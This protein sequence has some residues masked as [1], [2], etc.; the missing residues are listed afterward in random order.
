MPEPQEHPDSSVD[1]LWKEYAKAFR[2]FD[3]LSLAR[4]CSQTLSQLRG[5]HWRMSH[6]LVGAYRLASQVAHERGVWDQRLVNI[7]MGY[8]PAEC[9]G[10]PML[11]LFTREVGEFGLLCIHC[12]EP[13]VA[14][15]TLPAPLAKRIQQWATAY[16]KVHD[17]AHWDDK[18]RKQDD[19]DLKF[20]NAA[21]RV[22]QLL[23][24][25]V[26]QFLP[27]LTEQFPALVWED[28]DECLEVRPEDIPL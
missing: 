7:P 26:E 18:R 16:S 22:E 9:C 13:C 1:R 11:P 24:D 12:N 2:E 4:W 15:D 27:E 14:L 3:D 20:E 17:V 23:A 5:R 8:R 10:A 21:E 28:Q 6:P 25:A 19:Y